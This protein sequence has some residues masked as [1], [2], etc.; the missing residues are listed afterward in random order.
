MTVCANI[1]GNISLEIPVSATLGIFRAEQSGKER[2]IPPVVCIMCIL[3]HERW[4]LVY[5]P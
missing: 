3:Q 1:S 5:K 4:L 2:A